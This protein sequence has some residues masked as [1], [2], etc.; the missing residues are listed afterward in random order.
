MLDQTVQWQCRIS[1]IIPSHLS[2]DA[3]LYAKKRKQEP[4]SMD[5]RRALIDRCTL[6]HSGRL[7]VRS[8]V[9]QVGRYSTVFSLLH[10]LFLPLLDFEIDILLSSQ[11]EVTT[12]G[13]QLQY[14]PSSYSDMCSKR[15]AS[16]RCRRRI[17]PHDNDY[18]NI[19]GAVA[20][21]SLN[22]LA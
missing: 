18:E 10:N 16:C 2:K 8:R 4:Y 1:R 9:L 12:V 17:P 3:Y 14:L 21:R 5:E 22:A 15:K 6:V 11:P 13:V 20:G 7:N 19:S